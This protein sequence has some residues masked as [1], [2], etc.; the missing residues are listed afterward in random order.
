M[1]CVRLLLD[2]GFSPNFPNAYQ[3]TPLHLAY[4]YL[5]NISGNRSTKSTETSNHGRASNHEL[6]AEFDSNSAK[7]NK[8]DMTRAQI[9]ESNKGDR[10]KQSAA[11]DDII[12]ALIAAGANTDLLDDSNKKPFMYSDYFHDDRK[13]SLSQR[14]KQSNRSKYSSRKGNRLCVGK[15]DPK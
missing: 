12:H 11:A 10:V 7:T 3:Q 1:S 9:L 4:R 14:D 6:S 5:R 2:S 13:S 8:D 15:A